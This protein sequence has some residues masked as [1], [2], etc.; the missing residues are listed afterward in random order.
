[1]SRTHMFRRRKRRERD[2]FRSPQ[3][4]REGGGGG[5]SRTGA[6]MSPSVVGAD[7]YPKTWRSEFRRSHVSYGPITEIGAH[8]KTVYSIT[9]IR[10]MF[11]KKGCS[12]K[13]SRGL[14]VNGPRWIVSLSSCLDSRPRTL[15][16]D[17]RTGEG[18]DCNTTFQFYVLR[19]RGVRVGCG[20]GRVGKYV[21]YPSKYYDDAVIAV[22]APV[23]SNEWENEETFL[24]R[25]TVNGW[26]PQWKTLAD[27]SRIE[28]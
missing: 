18:R 6:P 5:R 16:P 20:D 11:I 9:D 2:G 15:A 17:N 24:R 12:T 28:Y 23:S 10:S 1:M 3:S 25:R 19:F 22:I 26:D 8:R 7:V 13:T 21:T 4:R 27:F 14:S